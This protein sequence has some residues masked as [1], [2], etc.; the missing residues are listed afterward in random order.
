MYDGVEGTWGLAFSKVGRLS[1][2]FQRLGTEHLWVAIVL[3]FFLHGTL[4]RI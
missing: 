4:Y 2:E 1:S 3:F